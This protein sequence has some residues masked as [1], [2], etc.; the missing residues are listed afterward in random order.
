M[1]GKK[2]RLDDQKNGGRSTRRPSGSADIYGKCCTGTIKCAVQKMP[3]CTDRSH[4]GRSPIMR[5]RRTVFKILY[6]KEKRRG[7]LYRKI[8]SELKC[9]TTYFCP[10]NVVV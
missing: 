3:L 8:Q 9:C 1:I 5:T 10:E 7:M 4:G 2:K 6:R